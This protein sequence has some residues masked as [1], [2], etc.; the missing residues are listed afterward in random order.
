MRKENLTISPRDEGYGNGNAFYAELEDTQENGSR[1]AESI[2]NLRREVWLIS[3][4]TGVN[5][6]LLLRIIAER[7][8]HILGLSKLIPARK[9]SRKFGP[10]EER[11]QIIFEAKKIVTY[12]MNNTIS[13]LLSIPL[14][15]RKNLEQAL[16][17]IRYYLSENFYESIARREDPLINGFGPNIE[18]D[19]KSI[20]GVV[21]AVELIR[22]VHAQS[23]DATLPFIGIPTPMEDLDGIDIKIG[24]Y[25]VQV[26]TGGDNWVLASTPKELEAVRRLSGK[27]RNGRVV[28]INRSDVTKLTTLHGESDKIGRKFLFIGVPRTNLSWTSGE[29]SEKDK[30]HEESLAVVVDAIIEINGQTTKFSPSVI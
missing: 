21:K 7:H 11:D 13:H 25:D 8:Q 17:K 20:W 15:E 30:F 19:F 27:G 18:D 1:R 3:E 16:I 23:T 10:S 4:E 6:N 12:S 14:E 28:N 22:G 26:K 2:V 5:F 29:Y 9:A 24:L